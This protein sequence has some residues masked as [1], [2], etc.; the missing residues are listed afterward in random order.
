M[1]AL[2][3]SL[4][5]CALGAG[6]N[7]LPVEKC[8][9]L[10]VQAF[11]I[12]TGQAHP[13]S[14][15]ADCFP[16]DWPGCAQPLSAKNREKILEIKKDFDEGSCVEH[17]DI[18]KDEERECREPPIVYCKQGLCVFREQAGQT[19]PNRPGGSPDAPPGERGATP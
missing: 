19:N 6:C 2:G 7:K 11:D 15:D 14:S 4:L 1:R 13:C 9:E 8:R 3:L 5:L 10:R 16:S 12:L 18:K 17:P